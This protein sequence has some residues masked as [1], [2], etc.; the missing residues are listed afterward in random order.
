MPRVRPAIACGAANG[1]VRLGLR[2]TCAAR[3]GGIH[4]YRGQKRYIY[5][6][7][8]DRRDRRRPRTRWDDSAHLA[9]HCVART[10][11]ALSTCR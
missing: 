1:G 5:E 2:C 11:V 3:A 4:F 9:T 8:A 10:L 6:K 7:T